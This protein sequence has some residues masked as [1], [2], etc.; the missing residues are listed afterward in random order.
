MCD[1]SSV[2]L[3]SYMA[4]LSQKRSF[5]ELSVDWSMHEQGY[6]LSKNRTFL[7]KR[8]TPHPRS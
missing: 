6:P 4:E 3:E 8:T 1:A 7:P 5:E 2:L